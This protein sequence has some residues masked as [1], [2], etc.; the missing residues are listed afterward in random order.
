MVNE[1]KIMWNAIVNPNWILESIK[2]SK[3]AIVSIH[4]SDLFTSGVP[5]L[6][7]DQIARERGKFDLLNGEPIRLSVAKKTMHVNLQENSY[8]AGMIELSQLHEAAYKSERSASRKLAA[9][10]GISEDEA[11]LRTLTAAAGLAGLPALLADRLALLEADAARIQ[12]RAERNAALAVRRNARHDG[13]QAAWRAWFD[14]SAHPNPGRC[15]I[16]GLL[17]GPGGAAIEISRAAGHGNSSEAEYRALIAVLEA[18]V[19]GGAHDLVIYGDSR[20]VIDDMNGPALY[21]AVSLA[22]YRTQAHALLAQLQG[23]TLR[24]I[25]RHKNGLA[26]ALSQRA[27]IV[28]GAKD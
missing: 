26:D 19:E 10:T 17:H 12:A 4:H 28:A 1:G 8:A 11:L 3:P 27:C 15:G 9:A 6:C 20:V 24:W 23:V 22:G 25:P 16:G 5:D 2:A 18:A 13:P 21:A 14:G 7:I